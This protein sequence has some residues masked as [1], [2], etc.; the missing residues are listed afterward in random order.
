MWREEHHWNM[1]V[2]QRVH[3]SELM[4]EVVACLLLVLPVSLRFCESFGICETG[5]ISP[6]DN[7]WLGGSR[8]GLGAEARRKIIC[9][10][11]GI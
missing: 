6:G 2:L 9:P 11:Q 10:C 7:R 5:V 1:S 4:W 3:L 8:A